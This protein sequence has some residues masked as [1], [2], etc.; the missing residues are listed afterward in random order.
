[1]FPSNFWPPFRISNIWCQDR[2]I[3]LENPCISILRKT[4]VFFFKFS[5]PNWIFHFEFWS[6]ITKSSSSRHQPQKTLYTNLSEIY[7]SSKLLTAILNF[8]SRILISDLKTS[9]ILILSEIY[10]SSELLTAILN[11]ERQMTRSSSLTSKTPVFQF[12]E[13]PE[14]FRIFNRYNV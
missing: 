2:D 3:N 13:K 11:F 5:L 10:A 8:G 6:P 4:F 12:W 7:A 9:C 1:M 14:L